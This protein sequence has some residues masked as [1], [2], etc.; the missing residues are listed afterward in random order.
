DTATL[1][2]AAQ[3][4][5]ALDQFGRAFG[6][7]P[8]GGTITLGSSYEVRDTRGVLGSSQSAGVV[9]PGARLHAS[10]PNATL[11]LSAGQAANKPS[12]P[13]LVASDG[14]TIALSSYNG[15]YLDGVMKAFAGGPGASGGT[16]SLVFENPIYSTLPPSNATRQ[17]RVLTVDSQY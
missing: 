2:V 8:N 12:S 15:F 5:T 3:A 4:V 13:V 10:G 1:N 6:V 11:D 16:L 17:L 14:G 7:V 9:R